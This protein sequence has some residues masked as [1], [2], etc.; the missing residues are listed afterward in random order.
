MQSKKIISTAIMLLIISFLCVYLCAE[1]MAQDA[2]YIVTS[3]ADSGKG[4]LR[5]GIKSEA[6][7]IFFD[8]SMTITL[9]STI[10]IPSNVAIRG[11]TTNGEALNIIIEGDSDP[12][13]LFPL[14]QVNA[15]NINLTVEHIT[16]TK[17][18]AEYGGV[19]FLNNKGI[20][21]SIVDCIFAEN[22]AVKDGG[23]VHASSEKGNITITNSTFTSNKAEKQGGA[24][25]ASDL[26]ITGST[27]TG[28][29]A[30]NDVGGAVFAGHLTITGSTFIENS[31]DTDF[32]GNTGGGAVFSYGGLTIADSVFTSNKAKIS[33][34]AVFAGHLTITGSTFTSNKAKEGGAVHS[35]SPIITGSTFI[36]NETKDRGGAIYS[37]S[38]IIT[39]SSFISN[40]TNSD[41]SND[42]GGAVYSYGHLTIVG[43][44]FTSNAANRR[45][46]GGAIYL[47]SDRSTLNIL[48]STFY[49]N[50]TEKESGT[51]HI[52]RGTINLLNS[53]LFGDIFFESDST[54][55]RAF[56]IFGGALDGI[57][58]QNIN[59]NNNTT[60]TP[61]EVFLTG[62]L[63]N[64]ILKINPSG[65][66]A[67][68]GVWVGHQ[69]TI[70]WGG[71]RE[72]FSII[73]YSVPGSNTW[74]PFVGKA[75]IKQATTI[76]KDQLGVLITTP[77]RGAVVAGQTSDS[78]EEESIK[79]DNAEVVKYRKAAEQGDAEALKRLFDCYSKGK[80]VKK[81]T[82]E[83]RKWLCKA[84]DQ[85]ADWA[86]YT[87]GL[88]YAEGKGGLK[89]DTA[90]AIKWFRKAADQGNANAQKALQKIEKN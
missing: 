18:R 34:G 33:G 10:K 90:E 61:E 74:T 67:G 20:S 39:D 62:K 51:I 87:L 63:K 14:F 56:N 57:Y 25:Y 54:V 50:T 65:P 71:H 45:G 66:A 21:L 68:T 22:K 89:K 46:F 37:G 29:K 52:K 86:Q 88:C 6:S 84:A 31:T 16:F 70:E 43:S 32:G 49:Q 47:T 13:K 79:Q 7:E 40:S 12:G 4:T 36:S 38:S 28:N 19:I 30:I 53:I 59:L 41:Y 27:F 35:S 24:V 8:S 78:D 81:D 23:A 2:K 76:T 72:K 15:G 58:T 69:D 5:D 77:S 9:A 82:A 75:P 55:N 44:T 42:G 3:N 1:S 11:T 60:A 17:G 48:N 83:A 85:G 73:S 64:N 26:T 80:G